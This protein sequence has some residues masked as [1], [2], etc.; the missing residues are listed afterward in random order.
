MIMDCLEEYDI[1]QMEYCFLIGNHS[2]GS[3]SFKMNVP[4]IMPLIGKGNPSTNNV[5]FNSNIF[6]NDEECKP[7]PTN[8]VTTQ[9]WI[10][11]PRF[12]N[13]DLQFKADING[14]IHSGARFICCFMDRNIR[15]VYITDNV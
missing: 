3:G 10:T 15:A 5:V 13:T 6:L 12:A 1:N 11:I 8:S 14:I 4:K 7:S 2:H 9:N